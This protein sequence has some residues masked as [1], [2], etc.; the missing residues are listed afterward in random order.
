[1]KVVS[2]PICSNRKKEEKVEEIDTDVHRPES[3]TIIVYH[4]APAL[5]RKCTFSLLKCSN[6]EAI[7]PI[8]PRILWPWRNVNLHLH[9]RLG[10]Q[11]ELSVYSHPPPS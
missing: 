11:S 2:R 5:P 7:T 1:M 3:D 10:T 9:S 6:S 4:T 8:T